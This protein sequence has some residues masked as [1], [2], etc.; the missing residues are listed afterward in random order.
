MKKGSFKIHLILFVLLFFTVNIHAQVGVGT[1]TPDASSMLDVQSTTKG[2]LIPRMTT[3]QREAISSPAN[4]LLVFDTVTDTF[5]FYSIAW[6]ELVSGSAST[7]IKDA[8]D[9]TK[10]EVEKNA[11]DDKI[12]LSTLGNERMTIDKDGNTRIGDG[13]NN[14][15]IED[16]G[17][18]SYEGTATRYDDLKVP[19]FSTNRDG[20]K[21]PNFYWFQDV[22]GGS[23]DG[24]QGV[25]AY[26]FDKNNEEEVYF[27]VQMPHGWS[28]GT[29]IYP[30]IHWSA[31]S[32]VGSSKVKWGLEYT[33]SNVGDAFGASTIIYGSDPVATY[34]PISAYEHA[35][36]PL[37]TMSGTGKSLSS[38]IICRVFRDATDSEDNY[39]ADAGLL[40]I[41]FHYQID[42]DGSR[43]Q[44]VK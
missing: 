10:I 17:S 41:D 24:S 23:G 25:F 37:P 11:D 21:P 12:R 13:V 3:T 5:W 36:T 32:N 18:L 38:M 16:D 39:G 31:K 8:D 44:Y 34:A 42:S 30:H 15:Y 20:S 4:G 26:W 43:E 2:M 1:T 9:D 7:S 40:E 22:N 27:M 33:W 19:V 14:T 28:E 6:E 35:I 29:D